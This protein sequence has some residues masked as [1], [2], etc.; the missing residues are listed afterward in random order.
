MTPRRRAAGSRGGAD[1]CDL[2]HVCP[3]LKPAR[4]AD[5]AAQTGA[6]GVVRASARCDQPAAWMTPNQINQVLKYIAGANAALASNC[7][8]TVGRVATT[9]T[10]LG[11]AAQNA[12]AAERA[13]NP[14]VYVN[15][16]VPGHVPDSTWPNHGYACSWQPLD[17]RVNSSL[18]GQNNGHPLGYKPT[19]FLYG[20]VA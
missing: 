11:R 17:R 12:T 14:T 5:L 2:H 6:R 9:G 10:A 4:P 7:L 15:G 8:S 1:G 3:A 13:A 18:A 20:G 19:V 16:L